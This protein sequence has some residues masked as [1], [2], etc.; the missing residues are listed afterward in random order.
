MHPLDRFPFVME[1]DA[2]DQP[3]TKVA[4]SAKRGFTSLNARTLPFVSASPFF[5]D[6]RVYPIHPPPMPPEAP[7]P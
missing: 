3:I 4:T 5:G 6:V 2:L 7:F 1:F